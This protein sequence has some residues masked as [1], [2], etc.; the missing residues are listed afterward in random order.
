LRNE[1]K[2]SDFAERTHQRQA[3]FCETNPNAIDILPNELGGSTRFLK[4]RREILFRR[5]NWHPLRP[6][7]ETKPIES[8]SPWLQ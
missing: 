6:F 7:W 2:S 8:A 3:T 1:P 4:K 5:T